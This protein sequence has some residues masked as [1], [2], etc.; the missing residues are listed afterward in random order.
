MLCILIDLT[1]ISSDSSLAKVQ[2]NDD[3]DGVGK[4]K[5]M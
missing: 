3:D 1:S 5:N 2:E 4:V